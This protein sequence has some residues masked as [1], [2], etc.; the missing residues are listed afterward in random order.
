MTP[1]PVG[2]T[3]RR[4]ERSGG[5]HSW[6]VDNRPYAAHMAGLADIA[7]ERTELGSAD[8]EHLLSLVAEWTI[9]A[10]L[11]FSDLVLWLPTWNEGGLVAAAQVRPTTAPTTLSHD[12]VGEFAPRGRRPVLDRAISQRRV[13]ADRRGGQPGLPADEEGIPVV[14]GGRAVAVLGRLSNAA[15]RPSGRL[16]EVYLQAADQLVVMVAEGTFPPVAGVAVAGRSPR[17]GDGLI[18]LDAAGRI[19]YATPNAVSA[20]HRL[21]LAVDLVGTE[22]SPVAARLI[23]R[24]G[25]VDEALSLI[26]AGALAGSV[27]VENAGAS[28]VLRCVPL[29][30]GGRNLG[31]LILVRDVTDLRRRDRAL[32]TKDATIRE[33]H[34][35]VKNNLQTVAALLR[36]QS[37][38]LDSPEAQLALAEAVA[39]IGTIAVVHETLSR[40]SGEAIG[41]DEVVSRIVDLVRDLSPT[42]SITRGEIGELGADLA[43]PLALVLTEL[44]ANAAEH[45]RPEVGLSARRY[46]VTG[47]SWL[48][49]FISDGG[50]RG[51]SEPELGGQFRVPDWS[52][53]AGGLGLQIVRTLVSSELGGRIEF[54]SIPIGP[55][56]ADLVG[57]GSS[58]PGAGKLQDEMS[59]TLVIVDVPLVRPTGP[60]PAASDV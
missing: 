8:V 55:V 48:Q 44:L 17:V 29:R 10:D 42:V 19:D 14:R 38:R 5:A 58:S 53:K 31:A 37:R 30:V 51:G 56:V 25:P 24:P 36:L 18:R 57:G 20:F 32:L 54:R 13:I 9:L 41:F 21:G 12:V 16:E 1:A 34:H 11:A 28:V 43:T 60:V 7:R 50:S 26:A 47:I 4:P 27:D 3:V 2:G 23:R 33:I 49:L 39:R 59:G 52:T 35:R 15:A 46:E 45:G 22:L 40:G 6:L